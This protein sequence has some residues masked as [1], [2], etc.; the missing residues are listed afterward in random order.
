MELR[1][2]EEFWP[3]Y[4]GEHRNPVCR[5]L[6]YIGTSGYIAIA[7]TAVI[8]MHPAMLIACPFFAYG[9]AWFGHFFIE[10]NKPASFKYPLWSLAAD[11]KMV[12][13]FVTGRMSA[14]LDRLQKK[15]F[16][17]AASPA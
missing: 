10:K 1:S 5:A 15:N 17:F 8:T 14:E 11:H 6:H 3:Y 9:F 16:R 12:A 7:L 2:F 4:M 13:Y